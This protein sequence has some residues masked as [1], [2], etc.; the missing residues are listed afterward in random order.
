MK[1]KLLISLA[2]MVMS[3]SALAATLEVNKSPNCGCCNA[4]VKHMQDNGFDVKA[5]NVTNLNNIKQS[6]GVPRNQASCHTATINGYVIEGHVPASAVQQ[7]LK[8]KPQNIT[9]ISVAGMPIG[10][11]GMESPS[12]Q[13]QPYNVVAF[14]N[15]KQW[16]YASF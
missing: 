16:T 9:G 15:D 14:N 11:P 6:L 10:S 8:D 1:K 5:N 3:S 2:T 4:W 12:G 13:T 7:L